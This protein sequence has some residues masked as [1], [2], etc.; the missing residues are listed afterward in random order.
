MFETVHDVPICALEMDAPL[1]PGVFFPPNRVLVFR[2]CVGRGFTHE[3]RQSKVYRAQALPAWVP[4]AN[5]SSGDRL[6]TYLRRTHHSTP[7]RFEQSLDR[8]S[9]P[10]HWGYRHVSTG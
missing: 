1:C 2:R 4:L 5:A 9:A 7:G 3:S 10:G 8:T 6:G